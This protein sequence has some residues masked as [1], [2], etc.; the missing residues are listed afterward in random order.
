MATRF[1]VASLAMAALMATAV[2]GDGS[3]TAV[4]WVP[5]R[6]V[7]HQ[8]GAA[9]RGGANVSLPAGLSVLRIA[10]VTDPRQSLNHSLE[11][12]S[13]VVTVSDADS[14]AVC[15]VDRTTWAYAPRPRNETA[16]EEI[17]LRRKGLSANRARL[18]NEISTAQGTLAALERLMTGFIDAGKASGDKKGSDS[19]AR[20]LDGYV[21]AGFDMLARRAALATETQALLRALNEELLDVQEQEGALRRVGG[22]DDELEDYCAFVHVTCPDALEKSWAVNV[23]FV[24]AGATWEP[25]YELKLD[26]ATGQ[27]AVGFFAVAAHTALVAWPNVSLELA[28][29]IPTLDRELPTLPGVVLIDSQK[30]QPVR[31][32][33]YG[34]NSGHSK[35][36][37]SA[38]EAGQRMRDAQAYVQQQVAGTMKKANAPTPTRHSFPRPNAMAGG[39]MPEQAFQAMESLHAMEQAGDEVDDG[40][41][42][43]EDGA[44]APGAADGPSEVQATGD[45][46]TYR[47]AV[48]H[49]L[50]PGERTRVPVAVIPMRAQ[51]LRTA[52]PR[53]SSKVY[54][55]AN[56]TNPS[57]YTLLPG[58]AVA[59]T[60]GSFAGTT[61]LR[62]VAPRGPTV[63]N[64]GVEDGV[65][66]SRKQL[67]LVETE[68]GGLLSEARKK[69]AHR[70][71]LT[72]QNGKGLPVAVT[73]KDT[74]PLPNSKRVR[75]SV[76]AE[77]T[78]H[79]AFAPGRVLTALAAHA[80]GA[81]LSECGEQDGGAKPPDGATSWCAADGK[82]LEGAGAVSWA[83]EVPARGAAAV[84]LGFD[85]EWPAKEYLREWD[86]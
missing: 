17:A 39:R 54:L 9:V 20:S 35:L 45:T 14:D 51:L 55:Q 68:S 26:T 44:D 60:D 49:T 67:S 70:Y 71:S 7:L 32:R 77:T 24:H 1:A 76:T 22:V 12:T 6:V 59:F 43:M 62:R 83:V 2:V 19:P 58:R 38:T 28:T 86:A 74:V 47:L 40:G 80:D 18:S 15:T 61:R 13:F 66:V 41:F 72:V 25:E 48:P 56:V 85:V 50:R 27:L 75:V 37:A 82:G 29:G 21:S 63:V 5:Q 16:D 46:E 36:A 4:P 65:S 73:L 52:V 8:A 81:V 31:H 53:L 84:P 11:K 64:I 3:S 57:G 34:G 23:S 10:N 42:G 69:A 79:K 78:A 33:F 30:D